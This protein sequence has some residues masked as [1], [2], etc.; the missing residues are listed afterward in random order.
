MAESKTILV[1]GTYDTKDDELNFIGDVIREQGGRVVSMDV[2]VLGNP[3]KPTDYSKHDVTREVS[4]SIEDVMDSEDENMAMQI[5]A[6]GASL[7]AA[8]LYNEGV[9]DG[10]ILPVSYTH[11][12]LPTKA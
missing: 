5:M 7:L 3:T 11:L 6:N 1:V 4:K 2:S 9:F 10:V 8:R 12:T